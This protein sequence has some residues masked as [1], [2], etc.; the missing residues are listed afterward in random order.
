M[1]E[2][3]IKLITELILDKDYLEYSYDL[4]MSEYD[5]EKLIKWCLDYIK[6]DIN[7][8]IIN[9]DIEPII[10]ITD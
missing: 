2:V 9:S 4:D 5:D 1:K 10:T 7:E 8:I 6:R 3:S